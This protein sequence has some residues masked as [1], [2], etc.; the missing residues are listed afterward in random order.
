MKKLITLSFIALTALSAKAQNIYGSMETWINYT[1]DT[2]SLERP[3]GW[4]GSDSVAYTI[5]FPGVTPVKQ[6]FKDTHNH[7]GSFSAKLVTADVTLAVVP[8]LI[9]NGNIEVDVFNQTF[10]VSGGAPCT[11]RIVYLNAWIDYQPV[12]GDVGNIT[13]N[14]V[15]AGQ[16]V[17]GTDSLVGQGIASID[18]TSGFENFQVEVTYADANVVPDHLLI[19]F[20]SSEDFMGGVDGSTMYVDDVTLTPLS[21]KGTSANNH[22]VKCFPNPSNGVLNVKSTTKDALT[23]NVYSIA[24]QQVFTQNFTGNTTADLSGLANGM[25]FYSVSNAEGATVTKEKLVIT[26]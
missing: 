16:G 26:K 7:S 23:L 1:A 10:N 11:E 5:M 24:G 12:G 13:V 19:A 18:Q 8:G 17:G 20:A 21:V 3:Q 25:Y 22:T 9:T 6:I 2:A 14:A 4:N 15:L